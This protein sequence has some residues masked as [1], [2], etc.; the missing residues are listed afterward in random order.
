LSI[1]SPVSEKLLNRI[2]TSKNILDARLLKL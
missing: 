2:R 1:D